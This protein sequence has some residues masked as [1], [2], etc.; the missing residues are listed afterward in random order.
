M[1]EKKNIIKSMYEWKK[2][3]YQRTLLVSVWCVF[4]KQN[5]THVNEPQTSAVTQI[6]FVLKFT[7]FKNP[8][9]R[10]VIW[11]EEQVEWSEDKEKL[12]LGLKRL[13]MTCSKEQLRGSLFHK[14]ILG[15]GRFSFYKWNAE[16]M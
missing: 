6:Y 14:I 12:I 16:E 10:C 4:I 1:V 3:D 2:R 7:Q 9:M 15:E 13:R 5:P 8:C 11:T